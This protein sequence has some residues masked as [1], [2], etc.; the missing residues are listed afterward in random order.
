MLPRRSTANEKP[1]SQAAIKRDNRQQ[2]AISI[3]QA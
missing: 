3:I 2:Q 1:A